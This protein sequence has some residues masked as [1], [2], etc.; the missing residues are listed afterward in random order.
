MMQ[1]GSQCGKTDEGVRIRD[2]N[3]EPRP[4]GLSNRYQADGMRCGLFPTEERN[5]CENST[6]ISNRLAVIGLEVG[7]TR[8]N[9]V[10]QEPDQC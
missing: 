3:G 4:D 6:S 8:I 9:R 5:C 10:S 1:Q 2:F 7:Y